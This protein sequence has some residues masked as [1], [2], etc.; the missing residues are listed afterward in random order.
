MFGIFPDIK[1]EENDLIIPETLLTNDDDK[2][3]EHFFLDVMMENVNQ[4]TGKLNDA[5]KN[6]KKF[7]FILKVIGV[8]CKFNHNQKNYFDDIPIILLSKPKIYYSAL[9]LDLIIKQAIIECDAELSKK[10]YDSSGINFKKIKSVIF[11][12]SIQVDSESTNPDFNPNDIFYR[13]SSFIL[14]PKCL[15]YK[16]GLL[17]IN[18]NDEKCLIYCC[19]AH[20]YDPLSKN[21]KE[22]QRIRKSNYLLY[23]EFVPLFNTGG[24]AVNCLNE[25][26]IKKIEKLNN[27]SLTVFQLK[28]NIDNL[29]EDNCKRTEKIDYTNEI[30]S[31]DEEDLDETIEN[32]ENQEYVHQNKRKKT[33]NQLVNQKWDDYLFLPY[34]ISDYQPDNNNKSDFYFYNSKNVNDRNIYLLMISKG[35]DS[36]FVLINKDEFFGNNLVCPNC[37]Q[38]ICDKRSPKKFEKH[39]EL[40]K[41]GKPCK[42]K[43]LS[44]DN[45]KVIFNEFSLQHQLKSYGVF[46]FE[47][48]MEEYTD[49]TEN[50]TKKI[51]KYVPNSYGL[52]YQLFEEKLNNYI[53][54]ENDDPNALVDD[55]LINLKNIA[56]AV[57]FKLND[58]ADDK[59][60]WDENDP[61]YTNYKYRYDNAVQCEVCYK[62]FSEE[63]KKIIH[64]DHFTGKFLN[65]CCSVCNG[66]LKDL[67]I[68]PVLAHNLKGFDCHIII[69]RLVELGFKVKVIALSAEKY[70]AV[71]AK[72]RIKTGNIV[73]KVFK[74]KKTGQYEK[75]PIKT[76]FGENTYDNNGKIIYEMIEEEKVMTIRFL[77][78]YAFMSESLD[79]LIET[80]KLA[81]KTTLKK[82]DEMEKSFKH[83]F[84][85]LRNKMGL[86]DDQISLLLQKGIYPYGYINNFSKLYEGI[87]NKNAFNDILSSKSKTD[88]Y[89]I[90]EIKK[91]LKWKIFYKYYNQLYI[92]EDKIKE[93]EKF[94]Y[95]MYEIKGFN[96]TFLKDFPHLHIA[97]ENFKK[98]EDIETEYM[99]FI[100]KQI[101]ENYPTTNDKFQLLF[102]LEYQ[103]VIEVYTKLKCKSFD[104]YHHWYLLMDCLLL[105]DCFE[106][107]RKFWYENFQV[108]TL[109]K[110]GLP[111]VSW[112]CLLKTNFIRMNEMKQYD[113][114]N[115]IAETP[116]Y[117][118]DETMLHLFEHGR[119]GGICEVEK[120]YV[121]ISQEN[122]L[123]NKYNHVLIYV[124]ANN[125]Y[126]H[127]MMRKLAYNNFI[128]LDNNFVDNWNSKLNTNECRIRNYDLNSNYGY[129]LEVDVHCP[130]NLHE[131]FNDYPLFP[132]SMAVNFNDLSDYQK[133]FK[134]NS[135]VKK[136]LLTLHPKKKY[137]V[138]IAYLKLALE[139]G[140]VCTFIHSIIQYQQKD[141]FRPYMEI[142]NKF[143]DAAKTESVKKKSKNAKN[144]CYGKCCQKQEN[145]FDYKLTK[146]INEAL[147]LIQSPR[148]QGFRVKYNEEDENT[149]VGIKLNKLEYTHNKNIST[150]TD[151][152]DKSK[153]HMARFFYHCIKPFFSVKGRESH[154][155]YTDT[156]SF[157]LE[158][159]MEENANVYKDFILTNREW[160][161]LSSYPEEHAIFEGLPDEEIIKLQKEN[162][163]VIGKFKDE[164]EGDYMTT[165]YGIR[166]KCYAYDTLNK[167]QASKCKGITE[168]PSI[169][170]FHRAL[171]G[172]EFIDANHTKI[173]SEKHQ[174]YVT[175]TQKQAFGPYDDKR[176]IQNRYSIYCI[177]FG[178]IHIPK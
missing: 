80:E 105:F 112:S 24:Y 134:L 79:S 167:K 75:I 62:F 100:K 61:E 60:K 11:E 42:I 137:V 172:Q 143:S 68:F 94:E 7:I 85:Y 93:E 44:K 148:Y 126:G 47:T 12:I 140:Y 52:Y 59:F 130:N 17:N 6:A 106:S 25:N 14:L 151:I 28:E 98:E 38:T 71:D 27:I 23:E 166:P 66:T 96:E 37:L 16:R 161:D 13:S 175:Q 54:S 120:K 84:T 5:L 165:F 158:L 65:V 168:T 36:H 31:N 26:Q 164:L 91:M 41:E 39:F 2:M 53:F 43:M 77:D 113:D 46:D 129:T 81:D 35:N 155:C 56:T 127:A 32:D 107:D 119:R 170:K 74:N 154:L 21:G 40:C 87:P 131:Y 67:K 57:F 138:T 174:L 89:Y 88:E 132:E 18:N 90:N 122:L 19:I 99:K 128:W 82:Y 3:V 78:S 125:L 177:P 133:S 76:F 160:F 34:R 124:D 152:L 55:L 103:Q 72:F 146:N 171:F 142:H 156:D 153:E 178:S 139:L 102:D 136:L 33:N 49:D 15:Q 8:G 176:F 9:S 69:L 97:E 63:T 22:L 162:K 135:N 86:N 92:Y 50:D 157:I 101:K 149:L 169:D 51:K 20:F 64:H 116:E 73:P 48:T 150:A 70:L 29:R 1:F 104:D 159:K 110:Y 109:K 117:L 10:I 163:K 144:I 30:E 45:C 141:W 4:F 108:D 58:I 95:F 111:G 173:R 83:T 123:N 147:R 145:Q 114:I 121:K 115:G 118:T